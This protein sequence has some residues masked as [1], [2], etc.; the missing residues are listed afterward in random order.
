M[1]KIKINDNLGYLLTTATNALV[2]HMQRIIVDAQIDVPFEQLR[3]LM[4]ISN[5]NGVKQQHI[6]DGMNKVKPGVSRL[7]DGL[8][9]KGLVEQRPDKED[10]RVKKLYI[11]KKGLKIREQFYPIGLSKLAEIEQE[12]GVEETKALKQHLRS[13]KEILSNS[14]TEKS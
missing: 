10:R 3:V 8:V 1:E 7:V 11:T 6:C 12:L 13:I 2:S 5:N 14:Q 4:F 9:K